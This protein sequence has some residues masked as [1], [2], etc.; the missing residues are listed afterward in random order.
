MIA[1]AIRPTFL[2]NSILNYGAAQ[3]SIIEI[4]NFQKR[5]NRR[6][7]CNGGDYLIMYFIFL[8]L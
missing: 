6:T 8:D 1:D 3:M 5:H 2:L 4:I 7:H